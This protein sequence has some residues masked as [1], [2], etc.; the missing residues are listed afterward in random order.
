MRK[1]TCVK[2]CFYKGRVY[3]VGEVLVAKGQVPAH[4]KLEGAIETKDVK[5]QQEDFKKKLDNSL[6]GMLS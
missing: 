3:K 5:L 6:A 1:Y 2:Q 4:F